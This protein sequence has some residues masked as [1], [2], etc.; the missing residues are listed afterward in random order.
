MIVTRLMKGARMQSCTPA[1]VYRRTPAATIEPFD[2]KNQ[3]SYAA[4]P[5]WIRWGTGLALLMAVGC[6]GKDKGNKDDGGDSGGGAENSGGASEGGATGGGNVG[7]TGASGG[8][9]SGGAPDPYPPLP[10]GSR[11]VD[12]VVNLVGD[13][14]FQALANFMAQSTDGSTDPSDAIRLDLPARVFYD[15]YRDEYDFL[16][17]VSDRNL[18][19]EIGGLH[20]AVYRDTIPGTGTRRNWP[21]QDFASTGRLMSAIGL[22]FDDFES[23]P[24]MAHEV[25]HH[26][27]NHLSP[28]LGFGDSFGGGRK[29]HWGTTSVNGQLGGFDEDSLRCKTPSGALP[30]DCSAETSGRVHYVVDWFSPLSGIDRERLYAP[31]E[32]YLMGFLELDEV[33]SSFTLLTEASPDPVDLD[34]N[35]G[36]MTIEAS[37][38]QEIL[39]SD[40]LLA[41]GPRALTPE[42]QR[43]YAGALIV[44]TPTPASDEMMTAASAWAEAFG[45]HVEDAPW[46]S[47]NELT[48]GRAH[49]TMRLGERRDPAIEFEA[50]ELPEAQCSVTAQDCDLGL[51]CY[52]PD[53]AVCLVEGS[54]PFGS[55]CERD[56][57]CSAGLG[58]GHKGELRLCSPYCNLD[59]S[60]AT[61]ACSVLCP[62]A[63]G[64][65]VDP[66][67]GEDAG[68]RCQS[69][70]G[71]GICDP[72][73]Q[74][75]GE[76]R[77]CF[78]RE[79]P[80]CQLVSENIPQ[81]EVCTP[82]GA[83]CEPGTTC[84]G[85][86]G[87]DNSYCMP[88]CDPLGTGE[89]SCTTLCP[90]GSWN[91]GAHDI[92]RPE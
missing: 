66:V 89:N 78:G 43:T 92:C 70:A 69:G 17:F 4:R 38:I 42:D 53:Q 5:M 76:G 39:M 58:C 65:I 30:P 19:D 64:L 31:L 87:G 33:P 29:S 51:G 47:F 9:G 59:D 12:H 88:Y 80:T 81:G 36:T 16:M 82:T 21:E 25:L 11:Q 77:G 48:G 27:A 35:A 62:D 37:G 52:S 84:I 91:F 32:N 68:G 15:Y 26:W 57:D 44:L 61:A 56:T 74:D 55:P 28:S 18:S 10:E 63:Y 24:P 54:T 6:G 3:L 34:Q 71:T 45:G 90:G 49:M 73:S 40:L 72:L 86:A 7:G 14:T 79:T 20:E 83:V 8:E 13:D 50:H 67:T 85:V 60:D 22:D 2:V 75:C 46:P 23:R 41:H 1:H